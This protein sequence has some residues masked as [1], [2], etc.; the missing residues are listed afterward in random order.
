ML[1]QACTLA[2]TKLPHWAQNVQAAMNIIISKC[3]NSSPLHS[4][5]MSLKGV[6]AHV[7]SGLNPGQFCNYVN[8]LTAKSPL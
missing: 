3:I 5:W 6:L 2:D 1:L 8:V 4:E 7:F